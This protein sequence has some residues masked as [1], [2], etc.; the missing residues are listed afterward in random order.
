MEPE[1]VPSNKFPNDADVARWS[2][3]YTLHGCLILQM[4]S[5][6]Y[7]VREALPPTSEPWA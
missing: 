4:R 3:D 6:K 7:R 5:L 2:K 1:I